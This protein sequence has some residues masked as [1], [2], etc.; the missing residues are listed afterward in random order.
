MDSAA[1][2]R[3]GRSRS[4][5]RRRRWRGSRSGPRP[6][7]SAS[8]PGGAAPSRERSDAAGAL[9]RTR[10]RTRRAH[11]AHQGGSPAQVDRLLEVPLAPAEDPGPRGPAAAVGG[12]RRGGHPPGGRRPWHDARAASASG[13]MPSGALGTCGTLGPPAGSRPTLET[14]DIPGVMVAGLTRSGAL[15]RGSA[16]SRS[17]GSCSAARSRSGRP[18]RPAARR[19]RSIRAAAR[20]RP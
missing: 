10:A 2:Q 17:G 12:D 20:E 11:P 14:S 16:C 7:C 19:S 1:R 5:T 15:R 18:S 9:R 6:R 13:R 4:R 8:R 3:H